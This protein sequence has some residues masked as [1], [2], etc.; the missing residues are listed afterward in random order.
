MVDKDIF[1]ISLKDVYTIS[2]NR[3]ETL[4]TKLKNLNFNMSKINFVGINGEIL[5]NKKLNKKY[6]SS[7]KYDFH[8]HLGTL[9]ASLSHVIALK[10]IQI[11]KL[12]TDVL[13]LEEDAP[14]EK[15]ICSIFSFLPK[16]YDLVYLHSY[17][18]SNF[19]L[20]EENISIKDI[21]PNG[22]YH[23][24]KQSSIS[25]DLKYQNINKLF[26][27]I[28]KPPNYNTP[29]GIPIL[30]VNGRNIDKILKEL[31]PIKESADWHYL[32][33]FGKLNQYYV[34]PESKVGSQPDMISLRAAI[35]IKFQ[36]ANY[37]QS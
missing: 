27:K 30:L 14:I 35:D 15:P 6:V 16:D 24:N 10:L 12:Y 21:M 3:T 7:E 19:Y 8:E 32:N 28:I 34:N 17:W 22:L 11:K 37:L 13:I 26:K 4:M 36:S 18:E 25:Q 1:I 23:N 31:L 9:G 29:T 5:A 33:Q 2:K 20:Q